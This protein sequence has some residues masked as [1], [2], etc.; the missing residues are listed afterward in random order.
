MP[1]K[2]TMPTQLPWCRRISSS[3]EK[4]QKQPYQKIIKITSKNINEKKI[5]SIIKKT[6][7]KIKGYKIGYKF[8]LE[9]MNSKKGR[10]FI[11]KLKNK[12][13]CQIWEL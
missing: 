6:Q 11:S 7:I 9:F 10:E 5:K 8:G 1:K 13:I 2:N 12:I 4:S 3:Y